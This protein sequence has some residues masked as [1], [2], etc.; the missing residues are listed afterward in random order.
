M[1]NLGLKDKRTRF[2]PQR[3]Y[4]DGNYDKFKLYVNNMVAE[5]TKIDG[6]LG[7]EY[8]LLPDYRNSQFGDQAY[9][10]VNKDGQ[11]LLNNEGVEIY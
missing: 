5:T 2:S 8:F 9:T 11:A 1:Q 4:V 10:I 7:S 6:I 3:K